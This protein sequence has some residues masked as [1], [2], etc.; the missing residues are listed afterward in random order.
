MKMGNVSV[1]IVPVPDMYI[2]KSIYE[3][4]AFK[5]QTKKKYYIEKE[6]QRNIKNINI[7]NNMSFNKTIMSNLEDSQKPIFVNQDKHKSISIETKTIKSKEDSY[8]NQIQFYKIKDILDIKKENENK[9]NLTQIQSD[10]KDTQYRTETSTFYNLNGFSKNINIMKSNIN[11]I[12]EKIETNNNK[13][14]DKK[15]FGVETFKALHQR[16]GNK[17]ILNQEID[18]DSIRFLKTLKNEIQSLN[19]ETKYKNNIINSFIKKNDRSIENQQINSKTHTDKFL[20]SKKLANIPLIYPKSKAKIRLNTSENMVPDIL[21]TNFNQTGFSKFSNLSNIK[22][23]L[24]SYNG[25]EI[26]NVD[27]NIAT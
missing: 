5:Q 23:E 11:N 10:Y 16:N 20:V 13:H 19:L 7:S 3:I 14:S 4:D 21:Q 22:K 24:N 2:N 25:E 1:S 18:N 6:L 9:I 15:K 26:N 12:I 17:T 27:D 8:N